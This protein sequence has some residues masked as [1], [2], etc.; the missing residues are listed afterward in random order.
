MGRVMALDVGTKTIGVAVSDPLRLFARPL[1]TLS[2][3][4]VRRDCEELHKHVT[5]QDV[6]HLVVGLPLE[7]DGSEGRST[8]LARQIG[9]VMVELTGLPLTYIDERYSSVEAERHLL[10]ADVSRARRKE[11]IDQAAAVVIL[12]SFLEHGDWTQDG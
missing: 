2:R 3:Q 11:V 7:L 9:A 8:R 12:Q 4:G 5:A 6:D 1:Y 10:H